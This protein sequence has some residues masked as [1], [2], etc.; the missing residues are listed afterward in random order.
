MN[1]LT[2][3]QITVG[4]LACF[5]LVWGLGQQALDSSDIVLGI[6]ILIGQL[7]AIMILSV[8]VLGI[9]QWTKIF[10]L[11]TNAVLTLVTIVTIRLLSG[12]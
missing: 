5:A 7:I 3:A 10:D 9:L 1:D 8:A 6:L 4:L 12:V 11:K 2:K